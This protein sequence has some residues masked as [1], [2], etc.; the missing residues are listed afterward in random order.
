[1]TATRTKLIGIILALAALMA[2]MG[3]A[4]NA[5]KLKAHGHVTPDTLSKTELTDYV[6]VTNISKVTLI[7]HSFLHHFKGRTRKVEGNSE[8][9]FENPESFHGVVLIPVTTIN[10]YAFGGKKKKLTHNIHANLE[11]D[12]YPNITFKLDKVTPIKLDLESGKGRFQIEGELSV[13]DVTKTIYIPLDMELKNGFL[14]FK[15]KFEKLDMRDYGLQP[16]TLLA[17]FK[18]NP[19]LDIKLNIYEDLKPETDGAI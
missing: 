8:G 14:H 16:D 2:L 9:S 7:G 4:V 6:I 15:G 11:A 10:G 1:M 17:V 19:F 12:K 5:K 13:H 18:V 3:P